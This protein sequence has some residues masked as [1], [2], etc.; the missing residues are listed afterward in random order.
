M[1]ITLSAIFLAL[2]ITAASA[3]HADTATPPVSIRLVAHLNPTGVPIANA[4]KYRIGL[5]I[6]LTN[7]RP[8]PIHLI[9]DEIGQGQSAECDYYIAVRRQDGNPAKFWRDKDPYTD[10]ELKRPDVYRLVTVNPGQRLS[11]QGDAGLVY[12]MRQPGIYLIHVE[13]KMPRELGG[14]FVSSNEIAVEV[15]D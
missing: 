4:R 8:Y 7:N 10:K 13:R 12:D 14:N 2:L 11:E 9:Q 15:P 3:V 1:K 5:W 6:D